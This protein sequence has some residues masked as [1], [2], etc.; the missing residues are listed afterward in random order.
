MQ[1]VLG[2]PLAAKVPRAV[3]FLPRK[4]DKLYQKPPSSCAAVCRYERLHFPLFAKSGKFG[5]GKMREW[6]FVDFMD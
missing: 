5:V 3:E 6:N 2:R 4:T 1:M